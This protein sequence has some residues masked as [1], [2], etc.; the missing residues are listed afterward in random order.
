[1]S[2]WMNDP[3]TAPKRKSELNRTIWDAL[4][5]AQ[6]AIAFPQLDVH[7]DPP[8]EEAATRSLPRAS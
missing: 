4:K 5:Q 6:V 3:W 7:F 1:V 2:V 8:I